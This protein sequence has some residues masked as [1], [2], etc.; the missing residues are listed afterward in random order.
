MDIEQ[1]II[2]R[3]KKGID[4]LYM[5][6][7]A[8][9][10]TSGVLMA[11][12]FPVKEVYCPEDFGEWEPLPIPEKKY[13]PPNVAVDMIPKDP[14]WEGICIDHHPGHHPEDQRKYILISDG[15]PTCG[16]V[17]NMFKD[18][19]PKEYH[20]KV[21]VGL[22]GDG[23]PELIPPEIWTSCPTLLDRYVT[24]YEKFGK[25]TFSKV[26]VFLKLSS[27]INAP[28]KIPEKWYLSYQVLKNAK[29]PL[30]VLFDPSLRAAKEAVDEEERRVVKESRPIELPN[31]R[32][33]EIS[34]EYKI[35]RTL[36]WKAEEVDKK[37]TIVIN[38]RTGR[39]SLRGVLSLIIYQELRK[40]GYNINGHPGFGG[41]K[42]NKDQTVEDLIRDLK[43][44]KI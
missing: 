39:M 30:D 34:S 44:I 5:H 2:K 40:K 15:I 21:A 19:I 24:P 36:G 42:L 7:D 20:W 32:V 16:I 10:I 14:R 6:D 4:L 31:I 27:L 9:G 1:E 26:P 41:G 29:D 17:Y 28:P 37:T 13:V 8:D 43:S 18:Y 35:E 23:Q 38:S 3:L 12:A 25:V 11:H 33:W 22:T